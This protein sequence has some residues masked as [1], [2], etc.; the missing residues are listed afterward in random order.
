MRRTVFAVFALVL[1]LP[2]TAQAQQWNAEQRE[3]WTAL[4]ACWDAQ[5]PEGVLACIHDD[6]VAWWP[7]QGVPLNRADARPLLGRDMAAADVVW[8]HRKPLNIDVRGNMA[9][10]IYVAMY[11]TRNTTTGEAFSTTTNWTEVFQKVGNSWLLLTD[12]GTEVGGN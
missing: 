4:E 12:H 6:Y 2:L 7:N 5:E 9:I 8:S 3:V 1:I 11:V 10:V